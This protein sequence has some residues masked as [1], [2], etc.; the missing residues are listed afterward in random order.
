MAILGK[1][2]KQPADLID[3][4][5]D[6]RDWLA[7]RADTIASHTVEVDPGLTLDSSLEIAGVIKVFVGGGTDGVTYKVT[8]T[9]TTAGG[10]IKQAEISIAVRE[11]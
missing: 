8:C 9:V 5:I 7:D 10:R 2:T 4:D 1:F 3:Y 6:Y 11:T